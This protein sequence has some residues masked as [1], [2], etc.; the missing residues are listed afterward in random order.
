MVQ[1]S[2]AGWVVDTSNLRGG[3]GEDVQQVF[4]EMEF[5]GG[6]PPITMCLSLPFGSECSQMFMALCPA[7]VVALDLAKSLPCSWL[8]GIAEM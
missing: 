4:S 1:N 7:V 2:L 8:A 3:S 5:S 6:C